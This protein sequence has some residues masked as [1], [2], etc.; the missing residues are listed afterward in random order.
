MLEGPNLD[1]QNM[2]MNYFKT[3]PKAEFIF[4]KLYNEINDYIISLRENTEKIQFSKKQA[5]KNKN[6]SEIL[7][8]LKSLTE[9]HHLKLQKYMRK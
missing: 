3:M 1:V 8:V 2:V 7:I 5:L 6:L 4:K 9:G